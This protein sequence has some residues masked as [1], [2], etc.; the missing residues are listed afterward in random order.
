MCVWTIMLCT[1]LIFFVPFVV[2]PATYYPYIFPKIIVFRIIVEIGLMAWIPLVLLDKKYRLP[3]RNPI[4]LTL[5][6]FM[7]VLVL[8]MMTGVDWYRSFWSTQERMTGVFTMLHFYA[9]FLMMIS[10]FR[11]YKEW[12]ILLFSNIAV[13]VIVAL[14][15]FVQKGGDG[16]SF[17][18]LGNAL[19]LAV[20]AMMQIFFILFFVCKDY[21]DNKPHKILNILLI[22]VLLIH[23]YV[24]F[25]AGSRTIFASLI[26][27]SCMLCIPLF[28]FL[29]SKKKFM[30]VIAVGI[31]AFSGIAFFVF[32]NVFP[33]GNMWI[34][35]Q[36][37]SAVHRLFL[38]ESYAD[39][40]SRPEVWRMGIEGFK[41]RPILGWGWE[42]FS[43]VFNKNY[44]H[45][46]AGDGE[47]YFD[48]SHNQLVDVLALTGIVG[49]ISYLSFW[50]V[51]FFFL[52]KMMF[53]EQDI[54]G[55]MAY[56]NLGALFL[57]Y[58]LQNLTVFDSPV[59]LILL[60][61]S[62][63]LA[64]F[65]LQEKKTQEPPQ[66]KKKEKHGIFTVPD[67]VYIAG[68]LS[69]IVL[70]ILMN[71]GTIAPLSKSMQ[72][73]KGIAILLNQDATPESMWYFKQSLG[74]SSFTNSE[75]RMELARDLLSAKKALSKEE[76]KDAINFTIS[77][78][79]K[80]TK[81][82]PKNVRNYFFLVDLYRL[83]GEYNTDPL[84]SEKAEEAVKK[85]IELAPYRPEPYRSMPQLYVIK[86]D[87]KKA[88]E[89]AKRG[90][91]FNV[92]AKEI[93]LFVANIW[94][95][96]KEF[97]KAFSE[98]DEAE[99]AGLD[100]TEKSNFPVYLATN[101]PSGQENKK[102]VD[103]VDRLVHR[104]DSKDI[105]SLGAQ[106]IVYYKTNRGDESAQIFKR[107]QRMDP[108]FA[109]Q[110]KQYMQ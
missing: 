71:K 8:T 98:L 78:V 49:L 57:G 17:S 5:S 94:L 52:L 74:G 43:Y 56:A 68:I 44:Q 62:L 85:A 40:G 22:C 67:Y 81:E 110:I 106:A 38:F 105:F 48:R 10:A 15:G 84:F 21:K 11:T 91:D 30:P 96:G 39:L 34:K 47:K 7:G 60:Y 86:G 14:Y 61:F 66:E 109:E 65:I 95:Q 69:V 13:S 46:T 32:V 99:K 55:K 28:S 72:A 12:R 97:N 20:F 90:L 26:I 41:E 27:G 83:A 42:N 1:A 63:G 6:L 18:Y 75:I 107:I 2:V 59:S 23:V 29:L 64:Y 104:T 101:L 73:M 50:G 92:S 103:Y 88:E 54:W 9:W 4:I 33:T 82:Q 51:L 70:G 108:T 53:K 45:P 76:L 25:L 16:R 19:Y 79:Q 3:F 35:K 102:A 58:F 93:H 100:I 37:P 89:W 77:E 87:F 24:M 36:L 80:G 31:V